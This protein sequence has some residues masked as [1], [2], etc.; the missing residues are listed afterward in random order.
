LSDLPVS[1]SSTCVDPIQVWVIALDQPPGVLAQGQSVLSPPEQARANRFFRSLDRDRFI[2]AHAALRR[3]LAA[4]LDVEPR[5]LH[6]VE[7]A[8]GKPALAGCSL[9]FSLAHA[10]GLALVATVR[11]RE[12]GVDLEPIRA[13]DDALSLA[14]RFF[15][16]GEVRKLQATP[17]LDLPRAFFE[18]WTRK[19]AF[20]KATGLGLSYP[21]DSFD[22][23]F[24][25]EETVALSSAQRDLSQWALYDLSPAPGYSGALAFERLPAT[26]PPEITLLP[27]NF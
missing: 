14:R 26:P 23:T 5:S 12:L 25:P 20:V 9:R 18:C 8:H 17:A 7:G 15:S 13:F 16:P 11:N 27:W 19:E 10:G 21:L 6:F 1:Y 2:L 3:I 4:R 24:F 22:V